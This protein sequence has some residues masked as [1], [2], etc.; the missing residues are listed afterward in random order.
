MPGDGPSLV[1]CKTHRFYGHHQGDETF[2]YRTEDE[3]RD[4]RARDPLAIF[5]ERMH[6]EGLLDAADL[7]ELDARSKA[8][9]DEAVEF[10][11]AGPLPEPEDLYTH[12]YVD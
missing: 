1:E 12:V 5:R 9:L 3:E 11:E 2:R 7:D 10:A 8:L 4:A 6:A